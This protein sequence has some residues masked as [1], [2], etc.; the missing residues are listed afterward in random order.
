MS[1][2]SPAGTQGI[3]NSLHMDLISLLLAVNTIIL[4]YF[5]FTQVIDQDVG[6]GVKCLFAPVLMIS[7]LMMGAAARG[8]IGIHW[9]Y[10]MGDFLKILVG[11]AAGTIAIA[12]ISTLIYNLKSAA[13]LSSVHFGATEL[14]LF[15]MNMATAEEFF[16]NYFL[17]AF[18]LIIFSKWSPGIG[19]VILAAIMDAG[20]F[21][22][23]HFAV[24]GT[25]PGLFAFTAASRVI[26]CLIYYFT[27]D[28]SSPLLAHIMINVLVVS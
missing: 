5:I 10:N 23:Y 24:Y 17:F 15:Y 28:L 4:S 26:L 2:R 21:A 27:K 14:K 12:M 9:Q 3:N 1:R 20:V 22:P 7:G 13:M 8:T 18:L 19:G 11:A 16:F 25:D 6:L